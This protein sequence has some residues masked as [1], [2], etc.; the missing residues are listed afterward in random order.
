MRI[1]LLSPSRD[2]KVKD[3]TTPDYLLADFMLYPPLGLLAIS[4]GVDKANSIKV[5]DANVSNMSIEETV[6]YIVSYGPDVLGISVVTMRL[7]PMYAITKAVKNYAPHIKI[8]V[9][10]P[11]INYYP[12]ET[13][14]LGTIDYALPG[15]GEKTFPLLIEALNKDEYPKFLKDIPNLYYRSNGRILNNLPDPEP[16]ELD[17][18]PFPDRSLLNLQD[19]FTAADE[20]G[21]TTMY[22]SRGCPFRCVF[23]D[24]QGKKYSYRS[25]DKVVEEF[26][27]IM[28]LGFKEIHIF[29]DTFNINRQ[30]VI[31]IC[32]KLID[33]GIKISWSTRMRVAPFDEEMVSMMKQAGCKRLQV[34]VES[35][36]PA[37][38]KYMGKAQTLEQIHEF[39]RLCKVSNIETLAYFIVGFPK[40]TKEYRDSLFNDVMKLDPSF[41]YFNILSPLPRTEYYQF[42]LDDGIFK[43]DYWAEFIRK[44]TINYELPLPRSKELQ[45]E[46]ETLAD[47]YHRAFFLSPRF[48]LREFRRA[49][50]KPKLLLLIKI[51]IK[52]IL[53]TTIKKIT[54]RLAIL[55]M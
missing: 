3:Y 10:G 24:V 40:E 11:H 52:L 48:V 38:L 32:R 15:Y 25:A 2:G 39:F 50:F 51:G 31:N 23:C 6:Q 35:L 21:M 4:A 29:D 7:Y 42:L 20:E 33:Q 49:V 55:R 34:G 19:Y 9:G 1:L 13:M 53:K 22:S 27:L 46:L 12:M 28:K 44:P 5:L 16:I 18:L 43:K 14:K 41:V 26:E 8:V 47:S 45:E 17:S 30:R 54:N 36:D 37:I